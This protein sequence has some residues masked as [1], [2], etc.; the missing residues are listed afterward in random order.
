MKIKIGHQSG[1]YRTELFERLIFHLLAAVFPESF[2]PKPRFYRS[3][4]ELSWRK[5]GMN[6]RPR[7]ESSM[8]FFVLKSLQS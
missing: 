4:V 5:S 3:P 2:H 6:E 8:A 1:Q 7:S